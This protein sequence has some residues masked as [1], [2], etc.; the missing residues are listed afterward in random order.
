VALLPIAAAQEGW[1][2][3]LQAAGVRESDVALAA[4]AC[5]WALGGAWVRSRNPEVRTWLTSGPA[6]AL[7]GGQLLATYADSGQVWR[8]LASLA[9][10][11]VAAGVGG[12]KQ[13]S[14]PL[15]LGTGITLGAVLL[16]AGDGLAAVPV[17]AWLVL[18]GAVL[19]GLAVLVERR[20]GGV[21]ATREVVDVVLRR[22]R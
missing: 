1:W 10:G 15:V 3:S 12:W 7:L 22:Y 14:A 9:L 16:L 5:V 13:E 2:T 4:V 19:L 17:W 21:A 20:G 6:L 8:A 11:V 18:A